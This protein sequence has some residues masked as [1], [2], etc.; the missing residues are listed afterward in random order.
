M[1]IAA[2]LNRPDSALPLIEAGADELYCGVLSGEWRR[3]GLDPNARTGP[4]ANLKEAGGSAAEP[5]LGRLLTTR[6]RRLPYEDFSDAFLDFVEAR[7]MRRVELNSPALE[8][9]SGQTP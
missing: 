8:H 4:A 6:P 5:V 2:P 1:K 9:R 7:G 3:R